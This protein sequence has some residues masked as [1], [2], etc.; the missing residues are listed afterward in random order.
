MLYDFY[1]QVH[2]QKLNRRFKKEGEVEY[3]TL[4]VSSFI[5]SFFREVDQCIKNETTGFKTSMVWFKPSRQLSTMKLLVH[6]PL[7]SR[8]RENQKSRREKPSGL[9]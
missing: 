9:I 3:I 5:D 4:S 8:I 7:H 6:S 2:E 1:E